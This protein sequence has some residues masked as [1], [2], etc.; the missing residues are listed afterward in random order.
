MCSWS[1]LAKD[2]CVH[3]VVGSNLQK[4]MVK[5]RSRSSQKTKRSNFQFHKSQHKRLKMQ[6]EL[7]YPMVPFILSC[8]A[9]NML[10]YAF[11]LY[12]PSVSLA[13]IQKNEMHK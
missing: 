9:W 12:A 13:C 10:K 4:L 8:D 6:F 11:E 2:Y 1:N 7:C 5:V 3:C